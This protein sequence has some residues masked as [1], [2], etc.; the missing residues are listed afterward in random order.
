[1]YLYFNKSGELTTKIYHGEIPRQGNP[2]KL[3]VCFDL[4][5]FNSEAE[6]LSH[7]VSV[8]IIK[9]DGTL[10]IAYGVEYQGEQIFEKLKDS[11]VTYDLIPG[12]SYHTYF[13]DIP[14]NIFNI[15]GNYKACVNIYKSSNTGGNITQTNNYTENVDFFVE[16]TVGYNVEEITID[17]EQ[18]DE[19]KK[20]YLNVFAKTERK[21]EK[22]SETKIIYGTDSDG[23]QTNILYES[24]EPTE[25][26]IVQRN[27][28][29]N[30]KTAE[31]VVDDDAVTKKYVDDETEKVEAKIDEELEKV[32][33]K[34][35]ISAVDGVLSENDIIELWDTLEDGR[36]NITSERYGVEIILI[37]HE[38]SEGNRLFKRMTG[39]TDLVYNFEFEEWRV[40]SGGG[41]G[42][43]EIP[44]V[45]SEDDIVALWTDHED[46]KYDEG[47]YTITSESFGKEMIL[48]TR[49]L[50]IDGDVDDFG[51][52][53]DERLFKRITGNYDYTYNFEL[54]QW[55][56]SSG[57]G[58]T[59]GGSGNISLRLL[60][61]GS[62]SVTTDD[63]VYIEFYFSS[64]QSKTATAI[65]YVNEVKRSSYDV[66]SKNNRINIKNDLVQDGVNEVKIVV[67]DSNGATG[68]L[69]ITVTRVN[70]SLNIK[71]LSELSGYYGDT[72]N[73]VYTAYGSTDVEIKFTIDENEPDVISA[74]AGGTPT[75]Y[76]LN[77]SGLEIGYHNLKI[78]MYA[79]ID[80]I[81]PL[82][83]KL[84]IVKEGS[85]EIYINSNFTQSQARVGQTIVIPY[86][87]YDLKDLDLSNIRYYPVNV[88]YYVN[89]KLIN[90]LEDIDT[91]AK[92][93]SY[94]CR[95]DD[96]SINPEENPVTRFK[97]KA[98]SQ[99]G[100]RV[101]IK[102]FNI[103]VLEQLINVE[104]HSKNIELSLT[105][106]NRSNDESEEERKYWRYI[107]AAGNTVLS[108]ELQDFNWSTNGWITDS[109]KQ[110][111]FLRLNGKAN[112]EIPFKI[113][114]TDPL[115]SG[116]TIEVTFR[117]NKTTNYNAE[118]IS[119][120]NDKIGLKIMANNAVLSTDTIELSARFKEEEKIK[121]SFVIEPGVDGG[122][123]LIRIFINGIL[124]GIKQ[125]TY[126]TDGTVD[127]TKKENFVQT[128]AVNISLGSEESEID[129][130]SIRVY[131]KVLNNEE[132]VGNFIADLNIDE[133]ESAFNRNNI[134][135]NG[136]ISYTTMEALALI[137]LMIIT[138]PMPKTK[139]NKKNV[140]IQYHNPKN[141]EYDFDTF[142]SEQFADGRFVIWDV[143]GTSSQYYPRKNYKGEFSKEFTFYENG[144]PEKVY[145]MKADYMESSH[146]HNTGNAKI[147]N[148]YSPLFPTQ[149]ENPNVRNSIYGFP[150]L[151]FVREL[152][153]K[154][155]EDI[156]NYEN[157]DIPLVC[158]GV[159]NFNNDK[160]SPN[161][162]GLTTDKAESWELKN[163]T[164]P[165]CNFL[166][167]SFEAIWDASIEEY[168]LPS[169]DFE[170]RHPKKYKDYTALKRLVSWIYS[171]YTKE[172]TGIELAE[173]VSFGE[174]DIH[175]NE[176]IY[177]ADT[178]EYRL[179]RFKHEFEN[180][181]NLEFA[182]YYYVMMD[183]MLAVDSRAK[184]MFLDTLDGVIW[185][186]RWYDI[187]TT[188]GLNNEGG[189]DFEYGLEQTDT[190]ENISVYNGNESVLWN[191][192]G[193]AFKDEIKETYQNL[194]KTLDYDSILEI[195]QGEQISKISETMYNTDAEFKYIRMINDPI[196][197][198]TTFIYVAQGSRIEHLKWW[199]SNRFKYLDSKY[200]YD[201]YL[202]D[203]IT[204]RT[205]SPD[206]WSGVRPNSNFEITSYI[207]MYSGVKFGSATVTKRIKANI[208]NTINA[209]SNF[210]PENTET[211]IYG[212]SNIL[213]L[214]D[215]SNKYARTMDFTSAK[216]LKQ[217]Q[218]GSSV[219]G[220]SNTNLTTLDIGN[221]T[222]LEY[223]NISNCPNLKGVIDVSQ[224]TNIKEI[225]AS[226]SG[227]TDINLARGGNL[228]ILE[229]PRTFTTVN[230]QNQPFLDSLSF[231]A[232]DNIRSIKIL[233]TP[234]LDTKYL[235]QGAINAVSIELDNVNW[236][237]FNNEQYILNN[238][239]NLGTYQGVARAKLKGSVHIRGMVGDS[240]IAKWEEYFG[241]ENL[242]ITVD[243]IVPSFEV[244]FI[245][246]HDSR[247]LQTLTVF[248]GE[249]AV[250]TGPT[251]IGPGKEYENLFLKWD[252][253][254]TN[255]QET[256]TVYAVF[257]K[258][259][260]ISLTINITNIDDLVQDL[261]IYGFIGD[262]TISWGDSIT[263]KDTNE[264]INASISHSHAYRDLGIYTITVSL[265]PT[266]YKYLDKDRYVSI[267]PQ[268]YNSV[269]AD[270][271]LIDC[272]LTNF[273]NVIPSYFAYYSTLGSITIPYNVKKIN[274][275][276][277]EGCNSLK[278]INFN[279]SGLLEEIES[280]SFQ[281]CRS[282]TS[283]VI[284]SGVKRLK[285][286]CFYY[287]VNLSEV[288]LPN[289]VQDIASYVFSK[290][291]LET[292]HIPNS[293]QSLGYD[294][295]GSNLKEVYYASDISSWFKILPRYSISFNSYTQFFLLDSATNSYVLLE[296]L[297][298]PNDV[299]IV[300][301]GIFEHYKFLQSITI[302]INVKKIGS[303]SFNDCTSIT[304]VIYDGSLEDWCHMTFSSGTGLCFSVKKFI[305]HDNGVA[306]ELK[307]LVI[308]DTIDTLNDGQ[309][310]Y[311]ECLTSVNFPTHDTFTAIADY[312][313][314]YCSGLISITIP[315]NI[316]S[317][318]YGAFS[319]CVNIKN[320]YIENEEN[321]DGTYRG[322]GTIT[323]CA[324]MNCNSLLSISLPLSVVS[325]QYSAFANCLNLHTINLTENIT[326][327]G[328]MAFYNCVD[329][330]NINLEDTVI[331]II[332]YKCFSGC[333]S[334]RTIE[335]PSTVVTI[336]YE[337]FYGCLLLHDIT[338]PKSVTTLENYLF[339][340]CEAL[341]TCTFEEGINLVVLPEYC[342]S[343][344]TSLNDVILPDGL[345][346]ILKGCFHNCS[347][348]TNVTIPNSIT[349]FDA[350]CFFRCAL[351]NV[352]YNGTAVDWMNIRFLT[353]TRYD[354]DS[355]PH[356][357]SGTTYTTTYTSGP[358]LCF[359]EQ[360]KLYFSQDGAYN[361]LSSITV[362]NDVELKGYGQFAY[363]AQILHVYWNQTEK[364]IPNYMFYRSKVNTLSFVKTPIRV[365]V[366]A[367]SYTDIR[368][369]S[370][371]Y[372][373]GGVRL[374][375]AFI[376]CNSLISVN[377]NNVYELSATFQNCSNLT[378]ITIPVGVKTIINDPFKNA[379][380]LKTIY[381][382]GTS[383]DWCRIVTGTGGIATEH[384]EKIYV[385]DDSGEYIEFKNMV[386]PN[387]VKQIYPYIFAHTYLETIEI[388]ESIDVIPG[389]AFAFNQNLKYV[390][391]YDTIPPT[392][393]YTAFVGCGNRFWI[394]VPYG[395][396]N[397]Y[398]ITTN[399]DELIK[400][401]K[402]SAPTNAYAFASSGTVN[403]VF[404]YKEHN[405]DYNT[406]VT[407]LSNFTSYTN[408]DSSTGK[409]ILVYG[410]N[411]D[412]YLTVSLTKVTSSATIEFNGAS[413]TYITYTLSI[414]DDTTISE[415]SFICYTLS[416]GT[417][418]DTDTLT[419]LGFTYGW[420]G[421][422]SIYDDGLLSLNIDY[423][424]H[425]T[426]VEND[427][428]Y[429][430]G[431]DNESLKNIVATLVEETEGE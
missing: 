133:L 12:E 386:I 346:E 98:I 182:L 321:E 191:N 120:F 370:F 174:V 69:Y 317:I 176:I 78:E 274:Y 416:D 339:T 385:K 235:V 160:E 248:Q 303:D 164:S 64:F 184:N 114:A 234:Q 36:Y 125:Y 239:V 175:G 171:T 236:N 371:P 264:L 318:G 267:K 354:F 87:V 73:L 43:N 305:Y 141:T 344:C 308:P 238:L 140:R 312:S 74:Y 201:D 363:C 137:P 268:R 293:V 181:M 420:T 393:D 367:F 27:S 224:C 350:G 71:G 60:S 194:R 399:W 169:D 322:V 47:F 384:T 221:N 351:L 404:I 95:K 116:R 105:A 313:F 14:G 253:P 282:L 409:Y 369:L 38:D 65:V 230:I 83:Y 40:A 109:L 41:S 68:E 319:S 42:M 223:L 276:A 63:D 217:L 249:D 51:N 10:T 107:N 4:D 206:N 115:L 218:I 124:S 50:V 146:S 395:Y 366:G 329:L 256:T 31:P 307:D 45:L 157:M 290:S 103:K 418:I 270:R 61:P 301:D 391:L 56:I 180:Y 196:A 228:E 55:N 250:Y 426:M 299:E 26:T 315:S 84:F 54:E 356:D 119:C 279:P 245:Q 310:A 159:F 163:N 225:Y 360:S 134:L 22:T 266:G 341:K 44:G 336:E 347:S 220:Y 261:S 337:A 422:V 213:D 423:A 289:T 15:P 277:F 46:G 53:K 3:H 166:T 154:Q 374:M 342:F 241:K 90:T 183:I 232:Y 147:I 244:T 178:A 131:N 67:R 408:V 428:T 288:T 5:F 392:L 52:P 167:D 94:V 280:E 186:P 281:Y 111:T 412:A 162:L 345:S 13:K 93:W 59:G 150:I 252:K 372:R 323:G 237:L 327:I 357:T 430:V 413:S 291:A 24:D 334:L 192:F 66:V 283:V 260:P 99:D 170:A 108:A 330:I 387:A 262:Y 33:E 258:N 75:P 187:D 143:Q 151:I 8:E 292:I 231:D 188:Y 382:E 122:T 80:D 365:G 309:F 364:E 29:G 397:T 127:G 117:T 265:N 9:P 197:P 257:E 101:S 394:Y 18:Y 126:I 373:E 383:D 254:L 295:F 144:I 272:N 37:Q 128:N 361:A 411:G 142:T 306:V 30:I 179:A 427:I 161:V 199:L 34:I 285:S 377:L 48:M 316:T 203:F 6:K 168:V 2:F 32:G 145:T 417:I 302:P 156:A 153:D 35:G 298:I 314:S 110:E 86:S 149:E 226:G 335:I 415:T 57:G 19:L 76:A 92:S 21:V 195:L 326:H 70:L 362:T 123:N 189:L 275:S 49:Q 320:I 207:D 243:E 297:I 132:V 300:T 424:L 389:Y 152:T 273:F 405:Y 193:N 91:S 222:M 242:K 358:N 388:P 376:E 17:E 240:A 328:Q 11:E 398:A 158:Y 284:P 58:G 1:M 129:I 380:S 287:C 96:I 112:V 77:I 229:L 210:S 62:M 400:F 202:D 82:N 368:N 205:Y 294:A 375:S 353:T 102:E 340:N 138:G 215:L 304:Q 20:E 379:T 355:D 155:A 97:I 421:D 402:T 190:V 348:M 401:I 251:P 200:Q 88:E 118:I 333:K 233:N 173:P 286:Y 216:R 227:I 211:I 407:T 325:I 425:S 100:S 23:K 130:F 185:Y 106:L 247:I 343:N 246:E 381:Y 419:T 72:L 209:P 414:K 352:Y 104:P 431:F 7:S 390:K 296:S 25:N 204:M 359:T 255:I 113:F 172:A 332:Y 271:N 39:D 278:Q 349:F 214:G 198:S 219:S 208:T 410:Q 259:T 28:S 403:N 406:F 89:D 79:D 396:K 135:Q 136:E 331:D 165:R 429:Q 139:G 324:F 177:T 148:K 85:E 16:R 311:F 338:I 121:I 263:K 81:A 212:A 269:V 378:E